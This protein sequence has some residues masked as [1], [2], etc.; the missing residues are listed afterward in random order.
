MPRKIK[1]C[2]I[3]KITNPVGHI[4]VGASKYIEGRFTYYKNLHCW[5]KQEKIF[6]SILTFGWDCH[7]VEIIHKCAPEELRNPPMLLSQI[8]VSV[9]GSVA[10]CAELVA[11]PVEFMTNIIGQYRTL[12]VIASAVHVALDALC[13]KLLAL[14]GLPVAAQPR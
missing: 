8:S 1:T 4:Y 9:A 7:Q 6:L 3:Y 5:D 13:R 10:A 12:G 14:I 11:I 2:G